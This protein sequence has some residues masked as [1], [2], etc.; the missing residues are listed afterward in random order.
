MST[1][2][3]RDRLAARLLDFVWD[4]WAQ[5]GVLAPTHRTSRW[6]EDPEALLLLTFEVGRDDPRLFDEVL[7]WLVRNEPIVSTRRLRTLCDGPEDQRLADAVL[8][9]SARQRRR[10]SKSS[11]SAQAP[12]QTESLFRADVP[13][14]R[15][16]PVFMEFGL[17]RPPAIPSGKSSEPDLTTSI[18]FA[19]RLRHLLGVGTRAEAVRYLLTADVEGV[20]VADVAASSGYSK[21][22]IQEALT[23]LTAAGVVTSSALGGEQRFAMDRARWGYLLQIEPERF[24]IYRDWPSLMSAM[25]RV[26]RWLDDPDLNELSP[27]IRASRAAD[28]LDEIRPQ[29]IRAGALLPARLGG[30]RSWSDLEDTIDVAL[31]QLLP[32]AA[33]T[34]AA[35]FEIVDEPGGYRWRLTSATGRIVTASAEAYGTHAAARAAVERVRDAIERLSL[36]PIPDAGVYRWN[37]VADNG[38]ILAGSMESF[39]TAGDA[40]R[41]ARDARRLI[42][43]AAP[44]VRSHANRE[45]R[46]S[47]HV[48][49]RSDGRWEIKAEGATRSAAVYPT[50]GAAVDAARSQARKTPNG[51]VVVV[52]G[53]DGRIRSSDVVIP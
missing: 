38:R 23:S 30:E 16:D 6:A 20:A 22:N 7:D 21:R 28:L 5:M 53:R 1:S 13:A 31:G 8:E 9:W 40:E 41:A 14:F 49:P 39:A 34:H 18:N 32:P 2:A 4:E 24:P 52:H 33:D 48:L 3:L 26:M 11:S 29:L 35:V 19:F 43:A 42:A 45:N 12:E 15:T 50:Q 44:G 36:V 46:L 51:G 37:L 47:R 17:S 25:R 10:T 27:Y